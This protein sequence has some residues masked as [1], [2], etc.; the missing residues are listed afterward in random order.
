MAYLNCVWNQVYQNL[1]CLLRGFS[2]FFLFTTVAQRTHRIVVA[3]TVPR[4]W[5]GTKQLRNRRLMLVIVFFCLERF[6][7]RTQS[8]SDTQQESLGL[9]DCSIFHRDCNNPPRLAS[10]WV[11]CGCYV[12]H[13]HGWAKRLYSEKHWE[14]IPL[15]P[16]VVMC[17][18]AGWVQCLLP[19]WVLGTTLWSNC[20]LW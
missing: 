7:L 2:C 16:L 19:S 6:L 3:A 10:L 17:W 9:S 4:F 5:K 14:E 8:P 18:M 15:L 20:L 1:N 13:S 11:K 12:F